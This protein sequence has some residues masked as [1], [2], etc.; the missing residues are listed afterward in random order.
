MFGDSLAAS[1]VHPT[2]TIGLHHVELTISE[3]EDL[4]SVR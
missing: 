4:A 3:K 1:N 2:A